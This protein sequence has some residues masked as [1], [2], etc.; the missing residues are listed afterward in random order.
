MSCKASSRARTTAVADVLSV[1]SCFC[2]LASD[3]VE[4][5]PAFG[6]GSCRIR[7][8]RGHAA[9]T[10]SASDFIPRVRNRPSATG[11]QLRWAG[12]RIR[13]TSNRYYRLTFPS[14]PLSRRNSSLAD[15]PQAAAGMKK[16]LPRD[17]FGA[18]G[19]RLVGAVG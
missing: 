14:R 12:A 17:S 2:G 15:S 18:V 10:A 5:C 4:E 19:R 11:R 9:L 3:I 16:R 13:E 8:V 1:S 6:S 7:I